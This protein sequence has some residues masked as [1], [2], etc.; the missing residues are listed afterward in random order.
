MQKQ[1][2]FSAI[3]DFYEYSLT[4]NC[5]YEKWARYVV[6]EVGKYIGKTGKGIDVA[7][8][9]GYYT[10]ALKRAGYNVAGVD[11]SDEMLSYAIREAASE[12]LAIDFRK[13]DMTVL[14]SFEKVDF[15]TVIN[16][17]INFIPQTKLNKTLKSFGSCLKKG[18]LLHF[19]ISSEY[20]LKT[21]IGNQTFCEDEDDY[22]YIWF[23][24]L[25]E[26]KVDMNLS[27]FLKRGDLYVKKE[28][29]ST[30]YIYTYS[31]ILNA[32]KECGFELV[33]VAAQYGEEL[34][35]DSERICFSAIKK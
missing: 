16:D 24:S 14:K 15:I 4:H 11:I 3:A 26:D 31:Q 18:G 7:C 17:G 12:R 22:S 21:I 27:V 13:C 30:E 32:L 20:K 35:N 23:N 5:E 33:S 19:D 1:M 10:R 2:L 8:G 6:D 25:K 29:D 9:T 34:K 28:C